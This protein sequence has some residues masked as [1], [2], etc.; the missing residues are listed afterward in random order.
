MGVYDGTV[1]RKIIEFYF[2]VV[3]K[4]LA[5]WRGRYRAMEL[6]LNPL[7]HVIKKFY[8]WTSAT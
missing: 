1:V 2:H 6:N 3:I 8:I 5:A 7:L 4:K